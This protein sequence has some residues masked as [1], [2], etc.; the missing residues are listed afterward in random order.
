MRGGS[1]TWLPPSVLR[2][3]VRP[4]RLPLAQA[5][6]VGAEGANLPVVLELH[7]HVLVVAQVLDVDH[8]PGAELAVHDPV[9][10]PEAAERLGLGAAARPALCRAT[11]RPARRPSSRAGC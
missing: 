7:R 8:L 1:R 10:R 11:E 6:E 9:A 4:R 5:G 2:L 3:P